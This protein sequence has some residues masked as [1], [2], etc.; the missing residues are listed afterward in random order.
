MEAK[1]LR[2]VNSLF[3]VLGFVLAHL[4]IFQATDLGKKMVA[5]LQTLVGQLRTLFVTD[6]TGATS[7]R[8]YTV[9]R[10]KARAAVIRCGNAIRRTGLLLTLDGV[11]TEERFARFRSMSD[12]D[13][14]S[15]A[16][17]VLDKVKPVADEFL[18]RGLPAAVLQDFP[19]QIEALEKTMDNQSTGRVTHVAA[20]KAAREALAAS[21][22]IVA[23][24]ESILLNSP[25]ADAFLIAEWKSR[26]R[27]GP[28]ATAAPPAPPA[29]EVGSPESG[30]GSPESGVGSQV[31]RELINR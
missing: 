7:A 13:L 3:Q 20:K 26:K 24:L 2:R 10:R 16:T 14:V 28:R 31:G 5:A 4:A 25:D 22:P 23:A 8:D 11:S 6:A 15:L 18:K 29:P 1:V 21:R 19:T 27:I 9:E 17:A 12:R 30:V